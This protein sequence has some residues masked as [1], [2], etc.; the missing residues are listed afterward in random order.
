MA[1]SRNFENLRDFLR[2]TYNP[3]VTEWFQDVGSAALDNST[4]RK[5]AKKACFIEK[6]DTQNMALLK[7]MT[8]RYVVQQ[9]HLR[10]DVYGLTSIPYQESVTFRPQVHLFFTQ[11]TGEA[12]SGRRRMEG[13][14]SFRLVNETS[15]T[16]NQV[17]ANALAKKIEKELATPN[18][19][20]WKKGKIKLIYQEPEFG[21]NL[22][23][24]ALTKAEGIEVIKK[25]VNIVDS[26]YKPDLL[27]VSEPEKESKT[28]PSETKLVYG[29]KRKVKRWRPKGNV[30]FR[31][32]LLTVDGMQNKIALV[33]TTLQYHSALIWA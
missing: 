14:I 8:F 4:A 7:A 21:L 12:P 20:I 11:D 5:Q 16:I 25:V 30:K 18:N 13:Q 22:S 23:I 2:K 29:K 3:E 19:F 1:V 26:D 27:R 28:N 24:L 10:P 33:D 15:S 9:V 6:T 32:A 17:K 31:Y